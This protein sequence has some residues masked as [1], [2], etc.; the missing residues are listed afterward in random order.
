MPTGYTDKVQSGEVTE[1]KEFAYICARAMGA[2]V[3]MRDSSHDVPIPDKLEPSA[4]YREASEEAQKQ[5]TELRNMSIEECTKKAEEEHQ[6]RLAWESK[7]QQDKI[8]QRNR[9]NAMLERVREWRGA[10]EGLKTFMISQLQDSI[11]YDCPE[12][13]DPFHV[14]FKKAPEAVSGEEWFRKREQTLLRDVAR[15][16]EEYA[17]ELERTDERNEWIH[18]LRVSLGDA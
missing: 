2:L 17:K 4:Y 5:L 3:T 16:S 13:S 7:Y 11:K 9:Y 1:L 12:D 14:V 8:N 10:P 18:Q 6:E 15:T